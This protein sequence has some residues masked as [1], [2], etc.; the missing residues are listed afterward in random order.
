MLIRVGLRYHG[1]HGLVRSRC[2]VHL[3]RRHRSQLLHHGLGN[4]RDRHQSL[5]R[6]ERKRP[7]ARSIMVFRLISLD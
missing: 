7:I 5:G 3:Q 4:R 2:H 1:R 6:Q